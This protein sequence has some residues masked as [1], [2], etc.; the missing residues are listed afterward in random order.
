MVWRASDRERWRPELLSFTFTASAA[1]ANR[2]VIL[3]VV[4]QDGT[5]VG[6]YVFAPVQAAGSTAKY[7]LSRQGSWTAQ[8]A[9]AVGGIV[10][11]PLPDLWLPPKWEIVLSASNIDVADTFTA[12]YGAFFAHDDD[13]DRQKWEALEALLGQ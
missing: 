3:S 7:S 10:I 13:E 2:N 5:T 6:Q 4:G 1:V 11:G 8:V 12:G 9:A